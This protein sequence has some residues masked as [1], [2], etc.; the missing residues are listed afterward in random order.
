MRIKSANDKAP[1]KGSGPEEVLDKWLLLLSFW[2]IPCR[3]AIPC[4]KESKLLGRPGKEA[5]G[6]GAGG[7]VEGEIML[8]ELSF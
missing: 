5:A 3:N 4:G 7:W 6:V 1:S 8:E 2:G